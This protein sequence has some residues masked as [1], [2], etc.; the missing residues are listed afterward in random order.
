M[1]LY[2]WNALCDNDQSAVEAL[3]NNYSWMSYMF[4]ERP[5]MVWVRKWC[6]AQAAIFFENMLTKILHAALRNSCTEV[7]RLLLAGARVNGIDNYNEYPLM[8]VVKRND[9][10]MVA[11]L[12][13]HGALITQ[14]IIKNAP[15]KDVRTL[16]Q[17][18][19]Q[20]QSCCICFEH[21]K[22]MADMPCKNRHT[23]SFIC[24]W[25]YDSIKKKDNTCPCCRVELGEYGK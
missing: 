16:L 11:L 24:K 17:T 3:M 6:H 22:D 5:L 1:Q 4:G 23:N 18:R 14:S 2:L 15:S 7:E 13:K 20:D 9:V 21:L 25:C 12:L 19:Y 10:K 8:L